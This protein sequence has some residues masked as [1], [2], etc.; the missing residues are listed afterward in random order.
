MSKVVEKYKKIEETVV[1]GYKTI[2]NGVVDGF[3]KVSDYAI[4]KMFSK[5]GETLEETK[6][7]HLNATK[8]R[9]HKV[10]IHAQIEKAKALGKVKR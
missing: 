10:D 3:N 7:R 4:E 8:N 5:E 6:Q 9:P 1:N 2:E